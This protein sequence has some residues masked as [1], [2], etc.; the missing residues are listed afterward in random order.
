MKKFSEQWSIS[1]PV[2]AVVSLWPRR[3]I[4][5]INDCLGEEDY[6]RVIVDYINYVIY[7]YIV[8]HIF[9]SISKV[10]S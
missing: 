5:F 1:Y 2:Y 6:I 10:D 7:Y 4:K 9:N 3:F 8:M